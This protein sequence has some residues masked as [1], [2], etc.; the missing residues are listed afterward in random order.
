LRV[1]PEGIDLLPLEEELEMKIFKQSMEKKFM[2][3][4]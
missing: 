3:F 1:Q 2:G 4:V